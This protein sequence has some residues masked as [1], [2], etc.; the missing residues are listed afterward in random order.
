[1]LPVASNHYLPF[2]IESFVV[3]CEE[4]AK[5]SFFD[6]GIKSFTLEIDE[7]IVVK[8]VDGCYMS[9]CEKKKK[10]RLSSQIVTYGK[11]TFFS[12]S[13]KK[14][15]KHKFEIQQPYKY[16]SFIVS[17]KLKEYC[18]VCRMHDINFQQ[19]YSVCSRLSLW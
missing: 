6:S 5:I 19:M 1:M 3:F 11:I 14:L 16:S 13:G 15:R 12:T 17:K 2:N 9:Y 7:L 4:E 18:K 10:P 8:R